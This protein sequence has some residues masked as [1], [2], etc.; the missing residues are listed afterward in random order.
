MGTNC[1]QVTV[2]VV[3]VGPPGSELLPL[4]SSPTYSSI[5]M[6]VLLMGPSGLLPSHI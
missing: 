2:W 6:L 5:K 4:V 3:A 1:Q